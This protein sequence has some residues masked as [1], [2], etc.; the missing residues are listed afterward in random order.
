MGLPLYLALTAPEFTTCSL[1]PKYPAWM[2]CHFSPYGTGLCGL[3][4]NLPESAM[5]I[6]NDRI[7]PAGHDP[8]TVLRQ[9]RQLSPACMLLDFQ[10]PTNSSALE[11]T[12]Q[13]VDALPCPVGVTAA[14]GQDLRCP[15]FLPPPP[16]DIPLAE[17]LAPWQGREFWLELGLDAMSYTVTEQGAS[18]GALAAVPETGL[19]DNHLRCHYRIELF[20]DRAVFSLWRTRQDLDALLEEAQQLGVTKAIGLWQELG[21]ASRFV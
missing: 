16:P 21:P 13:I 11:L 14:W 5:V 18:P 3:P 17:H 10:Q 8:E 12:R 7:P 2:A 6:L 20:D 19:E 15:L 9:L 1:L 4:P